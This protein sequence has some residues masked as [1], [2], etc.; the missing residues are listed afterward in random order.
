MAVVPV[1]FHQIMEFL[2]HLPLAEVVVVEVNQVAVLLVVMVD[3]V[4]L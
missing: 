2:E 4:L 1:L 3:L